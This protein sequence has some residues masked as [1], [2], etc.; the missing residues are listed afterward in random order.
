M[1]VFNYNIL[2]NLFINTI[3]IKIIN[4][5][6]IIKQLFLYLTNFHC[7]LFNFFRKCLTVFFFLKKNILY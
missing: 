4:I 6:I 5:I 1:I 3:K 2:C 7:K